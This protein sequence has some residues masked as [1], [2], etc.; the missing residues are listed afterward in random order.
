[1]ERTEQMDARARLAMNLETGPEK[2]PPY[3]IQSE[4]ERETLVSVLGRA[5]SLALER[6]LDPIQ[7][8]EKAGRAF[9]AG[10]AAFEGKAAEPLTGHSAVCAATGPAETC[11]CRTATRAV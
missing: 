4:A 1:M 6:G 10:I 7:H 9:R 2:V 11:G 3:P 8:A 5:I